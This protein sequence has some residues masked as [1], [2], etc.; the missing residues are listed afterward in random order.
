MV[1]KAFLFSAGDY[2]GTARFP[3][4]KL[5]LPGVQ[6]DIAA[7]AKRLQQIEFDVVAVENAKKK[8]ML[9]TLQSQI[10]NLPTDAITIVYFTG[11]GGHS[12]GINY[13]YP[14]DFATLYEQNHKVED[15]GIDINDIISCFRNKG[16]LILILDSC[17]V[18]FGHNL[19]N[20]YSEMTASED[21]YIAYGTMFQQSSIGVQTGMS[22]FT[23]AICDEILSANIDVNT[24]F[25]NVRNN[26]FRKHCVQVP[27]SIDGLMETVYLNSKDVI[28]DLDLQVH[29]FIQKYGDKYCEKHGYFH[30]DDLIFIDAAQYFNIS[31]LDAVW[32]F[33]KVD[34]KIYKEKGGKPP[35]LTEDEYKVVTFLGL[36][37]S[38]KYFYFDKSHTWYYNGRQIRIGEI[39]P[40][41]NSMQPRI[42]EEGKEIVLDIASIKEDDI[43]TIFINLPDNCE[44]FIRDDVSRFSR[45]EKIINGTITLKDACDITKIVIESGVFGG[46]DD[47]RELL[48]ERNRNLCGRYTEY[49]PINGQQIKY[50]CEFK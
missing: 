36:T 46:G 18:D 12:N 5:D 45:K 41:P 13:V 9:D 32:K 23:E 49:D 37:K 16:R 43:V 48:G 19:Q 6:Y 30:G 4:A 27:V 29:E 24:L 38:H 21:V 40:L 15:A 11:H 42:P 8:D 22:W 17:R 33:R 47:V 50:S 35:E 39:P 34:N 28:D 1:K 25:T 2:E 3:K 10:G 26:I 20:Y 44:I 31:F 14:S 7:M